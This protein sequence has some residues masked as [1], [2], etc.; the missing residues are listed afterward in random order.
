MVLDKEQKKI[1]SILA[2]AMAAFLVLWKAIYVPKNRS[3]KE[4][5]S[6]VD[7]GKAEVD[8]VYKMIGRE[9]AL[10]EGVIILKE[11]A[12]RL[13][14]KRIKQK[15]ISF[16]LKGLSDAAN[17]SGVRIISTKYQMAEVFTNEAG[18]APTYDGIACMKTA[19][20]ITLE[21]TYSKIAHYIDLLE[22]SPRGIYT[23]EGFT[24]KKTSDKA[25]K[26]KGDLLV[27]IYCF[28]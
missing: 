26:L 24:L 9:V 1:I 17:K 18:V 25:S 14:Q 27:W 19:V 8:S 21:G 15:D 23:I 2:I 13:A 7:V 12:D 28:G 5:K 4:L 16:A 20:T 22:N 6:K 10:K 3:V 11:E